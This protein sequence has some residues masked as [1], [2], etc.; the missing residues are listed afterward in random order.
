MPLYSR[1]SQ[2]ALLLSCFHLAPYYSIIYKTRGKT[3]PNRYVC[4]CGGPG[5]VLKHSRTVQGSLWLGRGPT[6][7]TPPNLKVCS[8]C[9]PAP[10]TALLFLKVLRGGGRKHLFVL[11]LG[12]NTEHAPGQPSAL[13]LCGWLSL[14][15]RWAQAHLPENSSPARSLRWWG[16]FTA[17]GPAGWSGMGEVRGRMCQMKPEVIS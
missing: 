7:E 1:Q 8:K 12:A 17:A 6:G 2:S 11:E 5:R 13:L 3:A 10:P 4:P 15:A 9:P 14:P 16:V